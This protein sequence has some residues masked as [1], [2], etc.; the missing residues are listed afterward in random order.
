M[1]FA[2]VFM[3]ANNIG[4][5]PHTSSRAYLY[6]P[7]DSDSLVRTVT[8]SADS[9]LKTA[10]DTAGMDSLE[11]AIYQYNKMVDDSIRLDSINRQ[12]KN[13]IDAPVRYSAKDSL[14]YD[15]TTSISVW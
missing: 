3:M 15:A 2:V 5:Y 10:V 14:V 7:A 1:M 6:I 11:Y 12:K 13:G 4:T 9:I 8:L